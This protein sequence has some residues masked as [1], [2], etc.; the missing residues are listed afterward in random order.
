M[1]KLKKLIKEHSW[2]R[3]FG[4]PLPTF[5]DVMKQH[6]VNKLKEDWWDDMD[7]ASQAQ[8]IK[9][10]PGSKQAQQADDEAGEEEPSGGQPSV[11]DSRRKAV[12]SGMALKKAEGEF[13]KD[14]PEYEAAKGADD[15]AQ[16]E[17]QQ[18]KASQEQR[19]KDI[20]S[21]KAEPENKEEADLAAADARDS[22]EKQKQNRAYA[23]QQPDP[24]DPRSP[25]EQEAGW[26]KTVAD[27][28]E[29]AGEAEAK[30]KEFGAGRTGN[31]LNQ[32]TLT[33][34]GKQFRRISE[35]VEKQPK[36]KYEFSK[37]YQ[38]FKR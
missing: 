6:Q 2:D 14:S 21:G 18:A 15:E 25:A 16:G 23:L 11:D 10:H 8:Y 29:R 7:S 20:N 27:A 19:Q 17:Y 36:P 12:Q 31:E 38:R 35:G 5:E 30:A 28:E 3:E 24:R 34:N 22:V 1:L 4:D 9:D 33:V 37:F 13:G 32:E 26:D